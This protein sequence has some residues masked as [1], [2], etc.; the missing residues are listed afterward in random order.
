MNNEIKIILLIDRNCLL[1]YVVRFIRRMRNL[2]LP[3]LRTKEV[4]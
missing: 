3:S 1:P 4:S 2:N